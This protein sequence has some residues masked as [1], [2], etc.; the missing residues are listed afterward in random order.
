[1]FSALLPAE[2]RCGFR[3]PFPWRR[4]LPMAAH[5]PIGKSSQLQMM[6]CGTAVGA[7]MGRPFCPVRFGRLSA[8]PQCCFR[9]AAGGRPYERAHLC[10]LLSCAAVGAPMGRPLCPVRFGRLSANPQCCFRRAAGGRPYEKAHLCRS[11]SCAAVGA[12]IGRP[13][14][15]YALQ[16]GDVASGWRP[17]AAPTRGP[18]CAACFPVPPL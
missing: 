7:P 1:M 12:L 6:R 3:P 2:K 16:T 17:V 13:F 9:L 8:N 11:V 18:I 4:L 15:P 10:G 5:K 14:S